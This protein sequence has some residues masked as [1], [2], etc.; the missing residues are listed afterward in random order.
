[1][2][3]WVNRS[4]AGPRRSNSTQIEFRLL[5]PYKSQEEPSKYSAGAT[6]KTWKQAAYN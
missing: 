4:E 2:Q 1:M 6:D 5:N 3:K